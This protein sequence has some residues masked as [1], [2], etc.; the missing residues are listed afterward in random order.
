M[1]AREEQRKER[2]EKSVYCEGKDAS[3]YPIGMQNTT[4]T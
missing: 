1:Y 2:R 4:D 3:K